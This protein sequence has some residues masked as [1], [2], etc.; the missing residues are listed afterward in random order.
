MTVTQHI[1]YD[2][3]NTITGCLLK[4]DTL[5]SFL[6]ETCGHVCSILK[7]YLFCSEFF[8]ISYHWSPVLYILSQDGR[9]KICI[10]YPEALSTFY[11]RRNAVN[12]VYLKLSAD[13]MFG[14]RLHLNH[15]LLFKSSLG[16][17]LPQILSHILH[18]VFL[19][20]F[21]VDRNHKEIK[22]A[23]YQWP[24]Y[25]GGNNIMCSIIYCSAI[26]CVK[27][28]TGKQSTFSW[29]RNVWVSTCA[30]ATWC[31]DVRLWQAVK[32]IKSKG[33]F[34]KI[35]LSFNESFI[36]TLEKPVSEGSPGLHFSCQ[37]FH[38]HS[39]FCK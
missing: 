12:A 39:S 20:L 7:L 21:I 31:V 6:V 4:S 32:L 17:S 9:H 22:V 23:L 24:L 27:R 36:H 26:T 13:L 11:R 1:V 2:Y 37:H 19:V 34:Y 25:S 38:L 28:G 3:N 14:A 18:P 35:I 15:F 8:I 29:E 30:V 33:K 10:I 5:L 16:L